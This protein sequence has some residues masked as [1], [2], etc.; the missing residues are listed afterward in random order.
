MKF[1][2][3]PGPWKVGKSVTN[4]MIIMDKNNICISAITEWPDDISRY[5]ADARLI[6]AAPEM[7]EAHG[8]H[9]TVA[10]E[11]LAIIKRENY[12][13]DNIDNDRWQK[14]AFTLYSV[15][16]DIQARSRSEVERA[17]GMTIDEVLK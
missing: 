9:S 6:A 1:K 3:T 16:V 12:V 13:F 8:K 14:L 11:A 10:E 4:Q 2:H 5:K 17:T 15:L 7:L